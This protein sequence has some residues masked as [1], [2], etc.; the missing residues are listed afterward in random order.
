LALALCGALLSACGDEGK[1]WQK[2]RRDFMAFQSDVMPVLLRDCA[3]S[4]CHGAPERFFRVW[5]PG[6]TRL[7]PLTRAFDIM[8]GDEAS[9]NLQHAVSMID[10][11]NPSRSL[12]LRKPLAMEAGG[13]GHLG[14]DK[15]GRN[16][17]RT[18]NDDGYLKLSRWVLNA[19]PPVPAPA[20]Q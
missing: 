17:Y 15:F 7:N 2:P 20:A 18:V 5:G 1:G 13:A 19:P 10:N 11:T 14:A 9:L 8:T 3:F 6:R 16:V 4:T 12:L